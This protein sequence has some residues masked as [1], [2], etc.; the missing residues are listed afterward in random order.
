MFDQEGKHQQTVETGRE[1]EREKK[2]TRKSE[3]YL[4]WFLLLGGEGEE[5]IVMIS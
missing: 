2:K 3:G 1:R 4:Y 5:F